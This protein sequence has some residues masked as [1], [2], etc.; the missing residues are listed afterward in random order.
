MDH[1]SDGVIESMAEKLRMALMIAAK[2]AER[3]ARFRQTS[4]RRTRDRSRRRVSRRT[5]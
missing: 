2:L 5:G 4:L 3:A 1:Q